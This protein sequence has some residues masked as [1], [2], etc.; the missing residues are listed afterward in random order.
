M[1][2]EGTSY[3]AMKCT[4]AKFSFTSSI[5]QG[6]LFAVAIPQCAAVGGVVSGEAPSTAK[7]PYT[8]PDMYSVGGSPNFTA[9][10]AEGLVSCDEGTLFNNSVVGAAG[11]PAEKVSASF[12]ENC[13]GVLEITRQPGE[14]LNYNCSNACR[15]WLINYGACSATD[16]RQVCP[17]STSPQP[18]LKVQRIVFKH[19][20]IMLPVAHVCCP[21]W[22]TLVTI[23]I[24]ML[25]ALH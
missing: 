14:M 6:I 24:C 17:P 22:P 10:A 23:F 20:M 15:D 19:G 12:A 7:S 13:P 16:Y 4:G 11:D 9:L 2:E 8:T 21:L 18:A 1:H 25:K 5:S 3:L